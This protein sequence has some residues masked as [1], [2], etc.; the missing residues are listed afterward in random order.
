MKKIKYFW[1]LI[2]PFLLSCHYI[3]PTTSKKPVKEKPLLAG[4]WK[5]MKY[6]G[7]DQAGKV[8][9]PMGDSV[10]GQM[11]LD[12]SGR[13]TIQM[14]DA[15]RR[16]LSYSDPY[17]APDNQIRIAFLGYLGYYGTYSLDS[18]KKSMI[19]QV[20]GSSIPNWIGKE[21]VRGLRLKG[22]SLSLSQNA[23]RINGINMQQ[24]S[25]WI[26]QPE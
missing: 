9:Y 25:F 3:F 11:Q 8:Y 24:Y 15:G 23:T 12:T 21:Q 13:F 4:T 17:Y 14:M 16:A 5:L 22:D 19:F 1:I 2:F 26:R 18:S 20:K 10:I 6:W 7:T